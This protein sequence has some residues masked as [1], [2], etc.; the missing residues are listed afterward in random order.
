LSR[1]A[2]LVVLACFA[3]VPL[4]MSNL[5][6]LHVLIVM[7][8]F[9]IAA[10]SLNLLL[11]F[12]GQLSLGH[13]AFFGI[14]AYASALV[15]LGFEV[16]LTDDV[17]VGV[18]AKPVWL[19]MLV[20]V[21]I[22]GLAGYAIGRLA[23]KVR[24][25]YFVIVSISFAEVVRL[26][27]TNWVELTQGPMALNNIPVLRLGAPGLFELSFL[28]KPAYYYLVLAAAVASYVI[29]RRL[30]RSQAG[31]AMIALREN[32]PLAVSV[33]TDVTRYLVLATAVSASVAG[34]AGA[35]YAHYVRIVDPDIFLFIYTVTMVIMVV[36]GGKGTFAGP[37]VG[38]LIF[39]VVPEALR[40]LEIE[41]EMQWIAFGAL[42]IAIVFL[43]PQGIVPAVR[44]WWESR[45]GSRRKD[46]S[47]HD[48]GAPSPP[49]EG[50]GRGEGASPR[51]VPLVRISA[52]HADPLPV[53]TGRGSAG[54]VPGAAMLSVAGLS[55]RFGGL[56]AIADMTFEVREG[57]VLSLIGP[58][59]AGKT[60][61][62]N[63]VTGFLRPAAGDIVYRGRSIVGLRPHQ[64][65]ALGVV[66]TFQK[67]SLFG[68]RSV[69]DNVLTGLHLRARQRPLAIMLGLPSVAREERALESAAWEVLRFMGIEARAH[70]AAA[71]LP[72][73]EQRLLEVAIALAAQPK[74][75][76]LDEPVSG[77]NPAEK[78]RFTQTLDKIRRRDI[79][80]LLVEHDMR[81]VMGVSDRVICLNQGRIIADGTPAEIQQHP[82]VIRAYLG[83]RT[84]R[85]AG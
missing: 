50:E 68:G 76:L 67:T 3:S 51:V 25:A 71:A 18:G 66:R 17:A 31:R 47:W 52:P 49:S 48:A 64:I 63:A 34:A 13:V 78:A 53:R 27:A 61:A 46:G 85:A 28:R 15:S 80:L 14:G 36:T 56:A 5:Y 21:A 35:L 30:V 55:I 39:G 42:M 57:E 75:L 38:G 37:V 81:T 6:F 19:A 12:T 84:A 8:I 32:E 2:T 4:W 73:G 40:A 83:E 24:G 44:D 7:G 20:A 45:T 74:L 10:M 11:G 1:W 58:N 69:L 22:A 29:I 60:S 70:E 59:G 62:F 43:L 54:A 82:E 77:M 33:G 65:A 79:T 26:V 72:Y 23:F 16:H 9:I 41:P